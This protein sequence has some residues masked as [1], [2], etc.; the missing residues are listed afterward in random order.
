MKACWLIVWRTWDVFAGKIKR[1]WCL[2]VLEC[3]FSNL[4]NE[5]LMLMLIHLIF[6]AIAGYCLAIAICTFYGTGFWC[7]PLPTIFSCTK[8]LILPIDIAK[9]CVSPYYLKVLSELGAYWFVHFKKCRV[10]FLTQMLGSACWVIL[11]GYIFYNFMQVLG[12]LFNPNAGFSLLGHFI[13]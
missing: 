9:W 6:P 7:H 1:T 2:L 8:V 11:F 10:I 4:K 13:G 5:I 12:Y 3:L